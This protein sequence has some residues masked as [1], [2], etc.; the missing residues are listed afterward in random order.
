MV[1]RLAKFLPHVAHLYLEREIKVGIHKI[2][3]GAAATLLCQNNH[4][5]PISD[6]TRA[7]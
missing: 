2:L 1:G 3:P 7:E 5:S 4:D 6:Q